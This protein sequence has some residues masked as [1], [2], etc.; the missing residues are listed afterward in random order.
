M[1]QFVATK[2][3]IVHEGKVLVLRESKKYED[4]SNEGKYDVVGGR[5]EPGQHFL[6][7]LQREVK[8]ET[9]LEVNIGRPFFVNEWRP[10][11]SGEE[12]QIIG[13]FFVCT[14][15]FTT[16]KL[17]EDHDDYKWIDPK[18]Y[19]QEGIIPNLAK[20]FESFV[21]LQKLLGCIPE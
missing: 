20:A 13:V 17:S 1:K 7:S 14:P 10:I 3:F 18:N 15:K 9:G 11:K 19:Q 6:D 12:W 2:A 5:V 4:G 8:E 21:N 16:V